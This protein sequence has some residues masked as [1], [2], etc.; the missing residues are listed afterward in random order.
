MRTRRRRALSAGFT[1]L[2]IMVVVLIIGLI[3][4][5]VGPN[6]WRAMSS[7][8]EKIARNQIILFQRALG[9][10]RLEHFKYP[11]SLDALTEPDTEG[12]EPYLNSIPLDPWK[13]DYQYELQP[14]GEPLITC[15]GA[16]GQPGGD[17]KN[18]DISSADE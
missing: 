9:E 6:V 18:A 3:L 12:G 17:G 11:D 1:I 5:T 15:Y 10:Y 16:D 4:G 8:Q 7:S 13:N 2:E 14:D